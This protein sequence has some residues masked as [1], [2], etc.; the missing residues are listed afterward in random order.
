MA[1]APDVS[2]LMPVFDAAATLCEALD[3]MLAQTLRDIE[4]VAVDDGSRDAS[5]EILR[6]YQTRDPRVR[7]VALRHAGLVA[8]LNAGLRHCRAPLVARMDADD[9]S[10]PERLEK[11][12]ALLSRERELGVVG[13]LVQA[14]PAAQVGEGF[15]IY[16][17]WQNRL[18]LHDDICREIFIESPITHPSACVR[19]EHLEALGGYAD[20]GWPE[21]YDLWL[22]LHAA[23]VR[24]GKVPEV[25]F[26]WREH[27]NRLTRTDSRYSVENF[28]RVKARYLVEGPLRHRD[29]VIVW[30]AGKTGR[31]I[32]KHLLRNGCDLLAFV[33]IDARKIGGTMRRLPIVS[34]SQ[35]G[36]L[37]RG[38][39]Q[40]FLIAAVGSR[41]ARVLIR[42]ALGAMDLSEGADY[43]FVA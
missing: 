3:S 15:R 31:R 42:E 1:S 16:L 18:R 12:S 37:W 8:A 13:C 32:S 27:G 6:N 39:E 26:S 19:R 34:P 24:F 7:V 30:G 25:L 28:L 36:E 40:P 43:L 14:F 20:C 11:Q 21:D 35:V 4:I 2:V 5:L 41:G 22:R 17:E 29:G 38:C 23:G 9:I 10:H 33:D